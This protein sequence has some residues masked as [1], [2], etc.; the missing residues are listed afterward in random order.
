MSTTT[1]SAPTRSRHLRNEEGNYNVTIIKSAEE[2]NGAYLE[3]EVD[4]APGGENGLHYHTTFTEEFICVEGRLY[5]DTGKGRRDTLVLEPGQSTTAPVRLLHMFY[6]PSDTE[7][8]RFRVV[9]R[10]ARHFERTLRIAYGLIADGKMN[11]KTGMPRSI[12]HMAMLFDWGETYVPVMPYWL[13]KALFGALAR[14]AK[15]LGK[16]HELRKY[17]EG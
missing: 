1:L 3:V 8:V 7:R 6:N 9:I 2:T 4:L 10:P 5:I 13:Q 17:Y 11:P 16:D 12:W 15:A 14:L